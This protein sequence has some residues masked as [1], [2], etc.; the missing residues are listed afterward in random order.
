LLVEFLRALNPLG[1]FN[2][3]SGLFWSILQPFGKALSASTNL[4]CYFF[5]ND[6]NI[7]GHWEGYPVTQF[8]RHFDVLS[9]VMT[10]SHFLADELKTRF[11]VP[12]TLAHK[13]AV[14]E[15]PVSVFPVHASTPPR[16]TR[17]QVF[18]S[19]RFDRQKRVD[20]A[21]AI[22]ER[23][24]EADFH[25]WGES[26]ID[27]IISKMA[28]PS[29]VTLKGTYKKFEDLPLT[30]CDA[31]LYTAEWDGVPN[32][33]IEVATAGIPLVGSIAG[34]TGEILQEGFAFGVQ[35]IE[36]VDAYVAGLRQIL[37][38]PDTAR[39]NAAE[40]RGRV[41]ERRTYA[42]YEQSVAKLIA[43]T[44]MAGNTA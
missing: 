1:V 22:A 39:A 38:E 31:W 13:V 18:W 5:C 19:G 42:S 34:G 41:L 23:T 16:N 12:P 30:Q 28:K 4:Y 2:V 37:A 7:Y 3:N 40:L 44:D 27:D 15:T 11:L 43:A 21:F 35:D 14:L 8:Y 6:K 32:M 36:D 29:N 24:P 26:V 17:P 10:D 33:L 25:F 20:I 9:G